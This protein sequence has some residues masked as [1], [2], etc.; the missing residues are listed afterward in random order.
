MIQAK[1][2]QARLYLRRFFLL[3]TTTTALRVAVVVG[4]VLNLINQGD[5]LW[6]NATV[7][8][9]HLAMNY[10]VPYLVSSHSIVKAQRLD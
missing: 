4:T 9:P 3:P 8:W 7:S 2:A 6:G 10:L 1:T 5:V